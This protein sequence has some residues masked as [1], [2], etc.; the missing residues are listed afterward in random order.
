MKPKIPSFQTDEEAEAFLESADLT[1]FDLSGLRP[2]QFEFQPRA[3]QLNMRPPQKLK[4]SR[5]IK[6]RYENMDI[7]D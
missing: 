4:H 7:R 2:V 6:R 5:Q 1:K 3:A